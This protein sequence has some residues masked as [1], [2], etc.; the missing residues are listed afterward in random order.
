M[1]MNLLRSLPVALVVALGLSA[2][3]AAP[4]KPFA[5]RQYYSG[6]HRHSTHGYHYRYYHFK[7]HADFA[8]F[9]HHYVIHHANRPGWLY[10]YNPH[11]KRYWGRCPAGASGKG[12]YALL[13][14]ED[15]KASLADIPESAFPE[16][17]PMPPIPE[18]E[19]GVAMDLPPDDLPPAEKLPG[20]CK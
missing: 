20:R 6:W 4:A 3:P 11:T 17:G 2:P 5:H 15:R 8:G 12:Q 13:A 18:S 16:P 14:P 9:K 19:D 7:P 10:F 1:T